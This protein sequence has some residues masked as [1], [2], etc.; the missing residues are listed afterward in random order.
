[1]R[2]P[3]VALA[4]TAVLAAGCGDDAP[5]RGGGD[6][7]DDDAGAPARVVR[8][9][10]GRG[11]T[12]AL[13]FHRSDRRAGAGPVV[14]FLHGWGAI[15]PYTYG[16]W[17]RHL[18][19][20]GSTVI[21]PVYQELPFIDTV[22]PLTNTLVAL[23]AAFRETGDPTGRLVVAGHSAGGALSADYAASASSAGLPV[24]EAIY[25]VYGGRSVEDVPARIPAVGPSR[26]P[27]S[28][29]IL[30]LA[31]DDDQTVGTR[32]ARALVGG[33]TRVPRDR[34]RYRL[35]TA[36]DVDDHL[37]P[38]RADDR[39]RETFW[40]PLDRLVAAVRRPR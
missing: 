4:C 12:G 18:V 6:A 15:E 35:V 24:P 19:R 20:R 9:E 7:A 39:A 36:D 33:A 14:V 1:M 16:P 3:A 37:A 13:V 10:V 26:I 22:A 28:A 25:S 32:E 17:L 29:R 8:T 27:G 40:A 30:A 5:A 38:L 31:G 11:V 2:G 23:R 34:R 21:Y